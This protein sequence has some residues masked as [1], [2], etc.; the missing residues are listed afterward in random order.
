MN[1]YLG[2]DLVN[3]QCKVTADGCL[4][5]HLRSRLRCSRKCTGTIKIYFGDKE[6]RK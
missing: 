1:Y 2:V 4:W 5:T 6:V 3:V